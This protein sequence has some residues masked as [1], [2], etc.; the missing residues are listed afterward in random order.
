MTLMIQRLK[1]TTCINI[2]LTKRCLKCDTRI[3]TFQNSEK[4]VSFYDA[5]WDGKCL[6]RE[7]FS[8]GNVQGTGK[9]PDPHA[10]LQVSIHVAVMMCDTLV[11]TQTHTD[12]Q[13]FIEYTGTNSSATGAKKN[14]E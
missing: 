11:N 7:R 5:N 4:W 10:G 13:L 14:Y 3:F 1:K 9:C 8:R 12:R 6:G 2:I